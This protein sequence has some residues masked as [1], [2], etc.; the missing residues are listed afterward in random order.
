M[1]PLPFG[2]IECNNIVCPWDS[3]VF[4]V[5]VESPPKPNHG[6]VINVVGFLS[7]SDLF[8]A[9]LE[10]YTMN[11]VR[12]DLMHKA[13]ECCFGKIHS[14]PRPATEILVDAIK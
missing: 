8:V 9:D 13:A 11:E 3:S 4:T 6:Q 5:Q 2:H 7:V 14:I 1:P 10:K 12:Y